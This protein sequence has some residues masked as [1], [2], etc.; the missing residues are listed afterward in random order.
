MRIPRFYTAQSLQADDEITLEESVSHYIS[1]VLRLKEN[2][3]IVLFNGNGA[4]YTADIVS[5]H[6]KHT[7]VVINAQIS[8]NV[9][10]PLHI[11]LAQGIS[12]GDRMDYALQKAVE[13]GV[14]EITPINTEFCNV[15]LNE[16]RWEKKHAQWQ[17]VIIS[18]CEQSQRNCVPTLHPVT[19]F[20]QYIG[21]NTN[22][23]RIIL[24]P[25]SDTYLSGTPRHPIGF[26]LLIGPEG[27]F[28]EQEV[29]TAQQIGYTSVNLG[30]RILRTETAA[31]TCISILQAL[32]GDL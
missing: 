2:A 24:S 26:Q 9:E 23:K 11:H 25:G 12:K 4:D 14:T 5:P 18:A 29:Y 10:S 28:S 3:P 6:K 1:T 8:L 13:L 7:K 21:L 15:K 22:L 19:S 32:H 20:S 30:P 17:K 16:E 31:V 27:G